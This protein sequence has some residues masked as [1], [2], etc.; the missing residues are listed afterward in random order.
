[1]IIELEEMI[2][3]NEEDLEAMKDDAKAEEESDSQQY[4]EYA[5]E[6]SLNKKWKVSDEIDFEQSGRYLYRCARLFSI[7]PPQYYFIKVEDMPGAIGSAFGNDI[8]HLRQD[9][10]PWVAI[11]EMAHIIVNHLENTKRIPADDFDGYMWASHGKMFVGI[12][13]FLMEEIG[14][15]DDITMDTTDEYGIKYMTREEL[16]DRGIL[17]SFDNP[18]RKVSRWVKK[19]NR[20]K[21]VFERIWEQVDGYALEMYGELARKAGPPSALIY[22]DN[23]DLVDYA[24]SACHSHSDIEDAWENLGKQASMDEVAKH[25]GGV[26]K[27]TQCIRDA[28]TNELWGVYE[29]VMADQF[30]E[31]IWEYLRL[32]EE[33]D[34]EKIA[35]FD[36]AIDIIYG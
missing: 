7:A 20:E 18:M 5:W 14:L 6:R 31:L 15:W 12:L 27:T 8:V 2:Q 17:D 9:A 33:G 36:L 21:L 32:Q 34:C 4:R 3:L 19:Y 35:E 23:M 11:H 22:A 26:K 29:E 25:L 28:I 30:G 10:S 1:M 16:F 13:T 24:V